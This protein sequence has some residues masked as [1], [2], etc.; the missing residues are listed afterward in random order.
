MSYSI[1]PNIEFNN[2]DATCTLCRGHIKYLKQ[3]DVG[4]CLSESFV[5]CR[6]YQNHGESCSGSNELDR[7]ANEFVHECCYED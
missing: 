1:C 4:L 3:A 2:K 6:Y 5:Y 7:E